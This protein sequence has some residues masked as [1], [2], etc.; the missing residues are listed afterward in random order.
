M[1]SPLLALFI[2]SLREDS[3]QKL[4]YIARSGLVCV[5][6]LF[7][8]SVQSSMGWN[9][10]PGLQF[11]Q[12][13]VGIDFVFVFL[14]GVSY[15]CS[16]IS[17]EKEEMTLGLLRMTNLNPLS[18]LLGKSTSRLCTATLLFAAQIPFTLLAITLG[19]ISLHQVFAAYLALAAF[20]VLISNLALLGSVLCKRTAGAAVFTGLGI[21]FFFAFLPFVGMIVQL[22][23]KAGLLI[24]TSPIVDAV[25][26]LAE[27]SAASN[28]L[29]RFSIIFGTGFRGE[30][31]SFQ[32]WSN[33]IC[34]AVFF[35]LAWGLFERFCSEHKEAAPARAGVARNRGRWRALSAGRTW[36]RALAWKDFYFLGGGKLWLVI[37][38][39][40]YGAPIAISLCWPEKLGGPPDMDDLGLMMF[41]GMIG[42]IFVELA[43]AAASVFR[44][45][46]QG[47]T[48][49]SLAMLPKGVRHAAYEKL[50]GVIPS[51][52]SAAFYILLSLPLIAKDVLRIVR[53]FNLDSRSDWWAIIG[54]LFAISQTVFFLHLVANL[55]LRVKRGALP[56][57]IGIYILLFMFV[58][59]SSI[60]LMRDESGGVLL[61]ILT[62]GAT[63]FL[64]LNIGHRLSELAAED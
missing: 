47:Q 52:S 64:H 41:W 11:F 39:C 60:G 24:S 1:T 63:V 54:I 49:S 45:E 25:E 43:F 61:L 50:M 18:I 42:F 58:G 27:L 16:A 26:K 10:A 62:I 46:R 7:L 20:L 36:H 15:F 35:L 6:L 38:L 9:N 56:L 33:L 59:I 55:S 21:L 12:I 34:G 13:V 5:I 31:F 4:T 57:A 29:G 2:R 22:P 14:A 51:L 28:P 3:R 44:V 8:F 37:K 19:G 32:V 30:L 48:L 17:E 40:V 53:N 23:V